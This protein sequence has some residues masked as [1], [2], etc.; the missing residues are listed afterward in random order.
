MLKCRIF[1]LRNCR[2][3]GEVMVELKPIKRIMDEYRILLEKY[4]SKLDNFTISEY[5]G[6]IG[7]IKMFWY[8]NQKYVEYFMSHITEKDEVAFL[9]G[10]VRLDIVNNGHYEY[11]L[12]GKIRLI[13]DPLMKLAS[14][15]KGTCDE[16]NFEYTNKYLKECIQ[17]ILLLL[18]EY[19]DDFYIL[20]TEFIT[21]TEGDEYHT[22]LV[23]AAENMILSMFSVEYNSVQEFYAK[24]YTYEDIEKNLLPHIRNQLVFNSL[25]DIRISLR[26]RCSNYLKSNGDI[27]PIMRKM[28]DAQ[29]FFLLVSQYC[30]QAMG[31]VMTMKTFHMIPFIRNDVVFQYFT[32]LLKTNLSCEFTGKNYMDTYIPYV[33]QKAFDFSDREYKFVRDYIGNGKMLN[34]VANSFEAEEIPLPREIVKCVECYMSCVETFK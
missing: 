28:G 20:P 25:E 32:M 13:N 21:V 15:Y 22:A 30:M 16:I 19:K 12:V 4:E 23:E 34:V 8:R 1:I 27:M 17:D 10:A 24:N 2:V 11:V 18:R 9:A 6:I 14:F 33:V 26:D 3:K 7:E 29:L 5:K 31:I